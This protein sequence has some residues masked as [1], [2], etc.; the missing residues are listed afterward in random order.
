MTKKELADALQAGKIMN[1]LFPFS[2]GQECE[3]FKS[4]DWTPGDHIVYISDM[5][6]LRFYF[7][8]IKSLE[9]LEDILDCCYTGDDFLEAAH[10]NAELASEFWGLCDWQSPYTVAD[11]YEREEA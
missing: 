5:Y 9:D 8:P 4:K 10:G 7:K 2:P 1:D 3:I 11:E 6:F